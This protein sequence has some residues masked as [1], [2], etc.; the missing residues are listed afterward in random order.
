MGKEKRYFRRYRR[1]LALHISFDGQSLDAET[2]DYSITGVSAL[3]EDG[4]QLP[5]E[6]NV[7]L[8]VADNRIEMFGR[9]AWRKKVDSGLRVG[10][11]LVGPIQGSLEV[12]RLSDLLIGLQRTGKEGTLEIKSGDIEKKIYIKNGDIVFASS[13][14]EQ[15]RF[16][17]VLLQDGRI[18]K[19][20]YDRSV[21]MMKKTGK[22]QG[23]V[24]VELGY[25]KPH[26]LFLGLK[27]QVE[28]IIIDM[29][30][31]RTGTF[32]FREGPLPVEEV[33]PLN[34]SAANIIYRGIKNIQ[35]MELLEEFFPSLDSVLRLS[36][37][38][39]DL[40]QDIRLTEDDRKVLALVDGRHSARDIL[41]MSGLDR[42][43][44]LRTL[45]ML[46]SANIVVDTSE[47]EQEQ[48][49][50]DVELDSEIEEAARD[51]VGKQR[52]E[53]PS[54]LVEKIEALYARLDKIDHYE[55][56]GLKDDASIG[57]VKRAYY[58]MAKEFHPD[59]HFYLSDD[60]KGKLSA[61]FSALTTAYSVLSDAGKKKEYDDERKGKGRQM[62]VPVAETVEEKFKVA[63]VKFER[64]KYEEAAELFGQICYIDKKQARYYYYY[65]M[66]LARLGKLR[67]AERELRNAVLLEP[68]NPDY[69]AEIGH[70]Y[71][72]LGFPLRAR[73]NFEKALR[74]KPTHKRAREG[75]DSL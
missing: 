9:V 57:E 70:I 13:N 75:L 24:L 3:L 26:D 54:Q 27:R 44:A 68:F 67:E 25:M 41:A 47:V 48:F 35:D 2:L 60:M 29:F 65:G 38:P 50:H 71:L 36:P 1:R 18:T 4:P 49:G 72:E 8:N 69:L 43:E 30:P 61:I 58:S 19:E 12:Y 5:G 28:K 53:A 20:Q 66:S 39:L 51:S 22:K 14:Q 42:L 64:G 56:F 46:V 17:D 21:E 7:T 52:V 45:Y 15:D 6:L 11:E 63:L 10:I 34:L 31:L 16:G 37:D 59:K 32:Y 62:H 74:A 73:G 40:F 55:L 23:A 33:I